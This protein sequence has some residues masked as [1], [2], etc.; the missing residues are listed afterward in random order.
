M[1]K[2]LPRLVILAMVICSS[3]FANN[4]LVVDIKPV[5]VKVFLH[6]AEL[7]HIAEANLMPGVQEIIFTNLP[8][9]IDQ[10]SIQVSAKGNGVILSVTQ[11]INYLKSKVKIPQVTALEDSLKNYTYTLGKKN[12]S[13]E[14]FEIEIDLLLANKVL[15]GDEKNVTVKELKSMDNFFKER[16]TALKNG[17]LDIGLEIKQLEKDIQ[18]IKNQLNEI[19]KMRNLPVNE[20]VVTISSKTRASLN[21][22]LSYL[23]YSAG[24]TP[25]YDVRVKN[26]DEPSMLMYNANVWQTS[27]IDWTDA[28]I[29]LSTRNARQG[30]TKPELY[31]WFIDFVDEGWY[32]TGSKSRL[33]KQTMEATAD[34]PEFYERE[35]AATMADYVTVNENQL[36]VEFTPELKYSIPS[37]GKPHT[38]SLQE[39]SLP[40]R[41]EYYCAPKLDNDAFLI[42]YLAEWNEF[43]LLP[44]KANIYF[45]NSFVGSTFIDPG[46]AKDT[47][48]ISLGRDKNV[49]IKRELLKDFTEEKFLSSDVERIF[50]YKIA[51]KNNKNTGIKI[52]VEDQIPISQHEDIEVEVINLDGAKLDN[53]TGRVKWMFDMSINSTI[54][55]VFSYS[56]RY[57]ADKKITNFN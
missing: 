38:V 55:K 7:T 52:T 16:L 23:I 45:E 2:G 36:A 32:Q 22:R 5:N 49:I 35:D 33:M 39:Y 1:T 37:D 30:G 48:S 44:G 53:D 6:G 34:A 46:V 42:A 9:N 18:R 4:E 8:T 40:A 10:N 17:M 11:R 41:Y 13:R 26:I 47:L 29:I 31:T 21:I 51:V 28:V 54:E 43:N 25:K 20:I 27:G 12:N 19:N 56:V 57:P 14:V 50:T 24:W 15:S 3:V